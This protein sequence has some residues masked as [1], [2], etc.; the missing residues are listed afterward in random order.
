MLQRKI[1]ALVMACAVLFWPVLPVAAQARPMTSR[2]KLI[3]LVVVDQMREDYLEKYSAHWTGG[4]RRL[5]DHGAWFR[6]AALPYWST[7]TCAGHATVSTGTFPA[8]HG[9]VQNAW[10]D[11]AAG[12]QVDCTGDPSVQPVS[13]GGTSR[14]GD[15]AQRLLAPTFSDELRAQVGAKSRVV[16]FSLKAHGAIMLA[17]QR[18][19]AVTWFDGRG[20]WVTSTAFAQAPV[21]FIQEF[22][23]AHPLDA[24]FGRTWTKLLPESAYQ[25]EDDAVGERVPAG[26][27]P[28]F[29]HALIGQGDKPD[30]T[31]YARWESSPF[32]DAYLAEMA[33]SAVDALQLGRGL[34]VDFLG[35][36][37]SALDF[38]GHDYGPHSHEVQDVL[39]RLDVTLGALL[40]H[41][42]RAVGHENYVVA[43]AADHGVA[44][45]AARMAALGFDVGGMVTSELTEQV[46]KVLAPI[47]GPGP[48]IARFSYP[49]LYFKPGVYDKVKANPAAL[50]AVE[51]TIL[52]VPG[53]LR[54]FR[55][56]QLSVRQSADDR[57]LRAASLGYQR[58]RSGDLLILAKPYWL[59]V[60]AARSVA[61]AVGTTHGSGYGY[62]TRVPVI[63]MG[64]A[65]LAGEYLTAATPADI[66]PT[67]AHLV[68]IIPTQTDG[69]VLAEAIVPAGPAPAAKKSGQSRP[70]MAPRKP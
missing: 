27:K 31:F 59:P 67:L 21:P 46:E 63:L 10:W 22:V 70:P 36:S 18:P 64:P 44:P 12:A 29:P 56:E 35:L 30:N 9:I 16:T 33:K 4:L 3:V 17:G 53:V 11:R 5:M 26:Q 37:F 45:L 6:Q 7:V 52:A 8:T 61:S 51:K 34:G 41:L 38:V 32:S 58:D 66:V 55:A 2:P 60:S 24:D 1:L 42:D 50:E 68:G 69:R 49:D 62:D 57:Y 20:N 54:V 13:Y 43:L 28:T 19:D 25:F 23:K 39:A 14:G 40:A 47:L 65:F 48:H 15:S